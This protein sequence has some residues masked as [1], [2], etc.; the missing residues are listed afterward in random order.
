MGTTDNDLLTKISSGLF[1]VTRFFSQWGFMNCIQ[2]QNNVN[3]YSSITKG[4]TIKRY[5]GF[6]FFG[7][8]FQ[9]L[10][11][12][13]T[14]GR[15]HIKQALHIYMTLQHQKNFFYPMVQPPLMG[16]GLLIVDTSRSHSETS[17]SAGLLWTSDQPPDAETATCQHTNTHK[18]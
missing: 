10:I 4:R 11:R 1:A 15:S 12:N 5:I 3:I 13:F 2:R 17:H 6:I 14:S 8:I 18:G 9:N 16:Q 7:L